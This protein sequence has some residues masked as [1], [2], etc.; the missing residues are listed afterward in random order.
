MGL[1]PARVTRGP[2]LCGMQSG[3]GR[4]GIRIET[5]TRLTVICGGA[6]NRPINSQETQASGCSRRLLAFYS[7]AARRPGGRS[8]S[9]AATHPGSV[10]AFCTFCHPAANEAAGIASRP[11]RITHRTRRDPRTSRQQ[12][13][14]NRRGSRSPSTASCVAW[15]R[16]GCRSRPHPS[17]ADSRARGSHTP[18]VFQR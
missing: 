1:P 10:P 9:L 12:H 14:C 17:Q 5:R 7:S 4:S 13:R 15:R 11:G 6:Q 16:T 3:E 18:A 2:A 8:V